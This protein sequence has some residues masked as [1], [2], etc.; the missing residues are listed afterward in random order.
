MSNSLDQS[1]HRSD[2]VDRAVA[3]L[4]SREVLDD[5]EEEDDE[6]DSL[7]DLDDLLGLEE[8]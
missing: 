5:T 2:V 1:T 6:E 7:N 8:L 4:F 3:A